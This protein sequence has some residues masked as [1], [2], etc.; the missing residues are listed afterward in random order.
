[1][2]NLSHSQPQIYSYRRFSNMRQEKG[3][4]LARQKKLTEEIAEKFDLP[5]NEDFVMTDKGLSAFHGHHKS[6]GAL[7]IFLEAV[8]NKVINAGSVLIVESLDRLSRE[9]PYVA[10]ATLAALVDADIK[11]V[12]ASDEQVYSKETIA[13]DPFRT[14]IM[15]LLLMIQAHS[16]SLKKT[17]KS[18]DFIHAEILKHEN[19]EVA[20]VAGSIPFWISRK[21]SPHKKIKTGFQLNQYE[22]TIRLLVDMYYVQGKGLR[23]ISRELYS[24]GIKAPKGGDVWGVSTLS[25]I[26]CNAALCGRHEFKLEYLKHGKKQ[27]EAYTLESYY[28]AIMSTDEF[29]SMQAIKKRRSGAHRGDKSN[30]GGLVYLLT[31]YGEKSFCA[32]CGSSVGSQPQ[33]QKYR[34]RRRLHCSKHKETENCCKSIVQDYIEDAFL[35]S[36]ARHIDYNLINTQVKPEDI[37]KNSERLEDIDFEMGSVL[38]MLRVVRDSKSRLKLMEDYRNLED[39]KEKLIEQKSD[40]KQ[41]KI[42]PED[43]KS[44]IS[45][46]ND[47]RDYQNNEARKFVKNI[48]MQCIRQISVHMEKKNMESYGYPNICNNSLVNVVDVEFY[49]DKS[50]SI[51]VSAETNELLFSKISNEFADDSLGSFTEEQLQIWNNEGWDK[52]QEILEIGSSQD[53]DPTSAENL[54]LTSVAAE[55]ISKA[56]IDCIDDDVIDSVLEDE[57]D[58]LSSI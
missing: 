26:F 22:E 28:P 33:K 1:M 41:H 40:F 30:K 9:Q 54:W 31:D 36:V 5:I 37:I 43:I 57:D 16:E 51:F 27:K 14:M 45:K 20:D 10:Q 2:Q 58:N 17:E 32:K 50:L 47:A 56:F 52:L 24:L 38:D 23:T 18:V 39:E 8:E 55:E 12:T 4:S 53:D 7:G 35:V 6:K 44:F 21:P 11:V 15:S 29:E 49:T 19:G 3:R 48:L 42:S 13:K 34:I 46:V 25:S